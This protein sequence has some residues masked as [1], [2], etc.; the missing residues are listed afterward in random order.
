MWKRIRHIIRKEFI[1]AMRDPR[2]RIFIVLPPIIQLL[3][4]GYTINFDFHHIPIAVWD[5]ACTAQSREFIMRF[6]Q[7]DYF[8]LTYTTNSR[9]EMRQLIDRNKISLALHLPWDFSRKLQAG[10]TAPVQ[11]ILDGTDSNAAIITTRYANSIIFDYSTDILRQR[12]RRQGMGGELSAP[13]IIEDRTWFNPNRISST[14]FVPGVVAMVVMLVSLQLTALSIVRENEIG[15]LEQLLV[16]PIRPLELLM[17]K[18]I[19][20][21]IISLVDVAVVTLVAIYWFEVPFRGSPLVLLVGT[22]LFLFSTVGGGLFIS[23]VSS[24]QQQAMMISVF[25]FMPAILL[26]GLVFPI[27]NM[28]L[29]AQIFTYFNPL[30]YF[31]IVLQDLFLKGVGFD[32]LWPQMVGMLILG[33]A[34]VALSVLR[35]RKRLT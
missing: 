17:G 2:L 35:F 24:T 20:F 31:I 26:S 18:T 11:L 12:L 32:V 4:Y 5:E 21:I 7:N 8:D 13:L 34:M 22:L 10:Y 3:T 27:H 30:R 25:F 1:Q 14:S 29:L 6:A 19:P 9:E 23:T 15:T 28:P 33:V 16:S